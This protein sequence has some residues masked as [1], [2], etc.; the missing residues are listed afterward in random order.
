MLPGGRVV[1]GSRPPSCRHPTRGGPLRGGRRA[2]CLRGGRRARVASGSCRGPRN[3]RNPRNPRSPRSLCETFL[4]GGGPSMP[5]A[6]EDN[7][8]EDRMLITA[9]WRRG[10]RQ[11][12]PTPPFMAG[13]PDERPSPPASIS[14]RL[15]PAGANKR[16]GAGPLGPRGGRGRAALDDFRHAG[17]ITL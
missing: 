4:S 13:G 17:T 7:A 12:P 14:S 8:A 15:G 6:R 5:S 11:M 9:K 3:P 10:R 2:G 16:G 1:L